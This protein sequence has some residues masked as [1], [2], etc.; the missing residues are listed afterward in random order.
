MSHLLKIIIGIIVVLILISSVTYTVDETK[1]A[2]VL[3]F[4][5]PLRTI[6]DAGLHFKFPPPFNSIEQFEKRLLIYD[7]P[8]NIVVTKDKKN[9]VVDSYARWQIFDPLLFRQTVR[10]E[11]SAQAR[12]D[13]IIYSDLLRE[14]GQHEMEEIVSITRDKIMSAVTIEANNKSKEY[15]IE[16]FDVRIKRTDLPVENE[17][18]IYNRMRAERSRIANLYRSEGEEEAL[19]IRAAADK[20]IKVIMADAYKQ[21]QITRGKAEAKTIL[22]YA[23]AFNKDPGFYEFS[24]TMEMYLKVLDDQTTLV[25]PPETDLFKYLK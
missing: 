7:S 12:L 15:G 10:T 24:R 23:D 16:I 13:D 22:I 14:L 20:D 4:G 11:G 18:A 1:Q 2:I 21:S 9:L 5:K 6:T 25:L 3:Q 17:Q 8:P 19:K